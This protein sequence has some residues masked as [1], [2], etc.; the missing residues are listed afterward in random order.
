M[1]EIV[2]VVSIDATQAVS[3]LDDLNTVTKESSESFKTL[4]EAKQYIDRL[5]GSLDN[6]DKSSAEYS[7]QLKEIDNAQNR[8]AKAVDNT[9]KVAN[10]AYGEL[11]S[12]LKNLQQK[13]KSANSEAERMALAS[14]IDVVET[15]LKE[16]NTT[17]SSLQSSMTA[18]STEFVS[19]LDNIAAG[20]DVA[21]PGLEQYYRYFKDVILAGRS[22][23]SIF[24]GLK[25]GF[26]DQNTVLDNSTKSIRNIT[27]DVTILEGVQTGLAVSTADSTKATA[28][29]VA[30]LK[31]A[32]PVWVQTA[33]ARLDL[34]TAQDAYLSVS[35][36]KK[37]SEEEIVRA[38]KALDIARENLETAKLEAKANQK[39]AESIAKSAKS[40]NLLSKAWSYCKKTLDAAWSGF[41][42][43]ISPT[44]IAIA[45]VTAAIALLVKK[46]KKLK[47]DLNVVIELNKTTA[48]AAEQIVILSLL[49]RKYKELGDNVKDKKQFLTDYADAIGNTGIEIKDL[50]DAEDVFINNTDK[51]IES[52]KK[53]A[54]AQGAYNLLVKKT[55]NYLEERAEL[56]A[57]LANKVSRLPE[58]TPEGYTS[59]GID[60][61]KGK[62]AELD[63][64][65]KK[66]AEYYSK[67][68]T[69]DSS[70][71]SSSSASS[72]ST[73]S[74]TSSASTSSALPDLLSLFQ[75]ESEQIN[76]EIITEAK[77]TSKQALDIWARATLARIPS[78]QRE[79]LEL[80]TK[81]ETEKQLLIDNGIATEALTEEY[82]KN[83]LAI[84][85]KY[86][87]QELA[88]KEAYLNQQQ[89]LDNQ[90]I[91]YRTD[92]EYL[93]RQLALNSEKEHLE[94]LKAIYES[95][96]VLY[97][98]D[99]TEY[100]AVAEL[101]EETN[102]K[103]GINLKSQAKLQ[104][105]IA[106]H[107]KETWRS[108]IEIITGS[109]NSIAS[110]WQA[111]LDA[112]KDKLSEEGNLTQKEV[113]NYNKKREALKAFQIASIIISAAA[114][115]FD[116]WRG[117]N[118]ERVVNAETA[119]AS[120]P[121][122]VATLASLNT[123]SL[124]KA[125]AN[126][127]TTLANATASIASIKSETLQAST[128]STSSVSPTAVA[129]QYSPNYSTNITGQTETT[130]LAN[131]L[132]DIKVYVTEYDLQ[133]AAKRVQVRQGESTF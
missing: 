126:Q 48:G 38:K 68:I 119:A 13:F 71:S 130:N 28:T 64:N 8:L 27:R 15:K 75:E 72:A 74:S 81:F 22:L 31:A 124:V 54:K 87:E 125:I 106:Q 36:R 97:E 78:L 70:D 44:A 12:Q 20:L 94:Q 114:A 91:S 90:L 84:I 95:R 103:L 111:V 116:I 55:E 53:K 96:L 110:A 80:K 5:K 121:A 102:N 77:D 66:K 112:E 18:Y 57:K 129:T 3:T 120:G 123:A 52:L 99:S 115:S 51:Y 69:L 76:E 85:A 62:L 89:Q 29:E 25:T 45:A 24:S 21:I 88:E 79:L 33:K 19:G 34:M 26:T 118:L 2:K 108:N 32:Q 41:K 105:D 14:Q 92:N 58:T 40:V 47:E 83:R 9:G 7:N 56:E 10:R 101:I 11:T 60:K 98:K 39:V 63:A 113:D 107:V 131:A 82:E 17:V 132:S 109:I 122:A 73:A 65:Y 46:I 133:Q 6:L 35:A 23:G 61:L 128:A 16:M 93:Q 117:Y 4:G 37:S 104:E 86:R 30:T 100:K 42:R 59:L 1:E 49:S 127:A 67:Y 43:L 50:N